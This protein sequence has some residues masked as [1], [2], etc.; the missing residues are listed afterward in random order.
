MQS[1]TTS[2]PGDALMKYSR[3]CAIAAGCVIREYSTSFGASVKLLGKR[4]RSHIRNVYALVR[5][6]DEL[7]DGVATE[8]GINAATQATLLNALEQ[9]T[10]A[11]MQTGYSTNPIVHAFALTARQCGIDRSLTEPFFASMRIDI[12]QGTTGSREPSNKVRDFNAEEHA[13]Y[14]YGSAEVIGLMCMRVFTRDLTPTPEEAE[15]LT[16]GARDLGAAFQNIN[17]LRD[18]ADDSERLQRNY[19]GVADRLT[20][21]ERHE[22]IT[23]IHHQLASARATLPLLPK[24]ARRA[25]RC[26]LDLFAALTLRLA[27]VS[28]T[29]LYRRRIRVPNPIKLML[30]TRAST[31]TALERA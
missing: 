26:A 18:L 24:D 11:A 4:H 1:S 8:A 31:R 14:V 29:E 7:V 20:D 23:T 6:A 9:Q 3:T 17:F 15:Q 2:P 12:D 27:R 28:A 30:L 25:V 22:W 16:T 5:I 19:L 21:A 13:E 10:D